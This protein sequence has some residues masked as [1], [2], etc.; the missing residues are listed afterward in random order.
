MEISE[1][2]G[3]TLR[4]RKQVVIRRNPIV[5]ELSLPS[6]DVYQTLSTL[7]WI[8]LALLPLVLGIAVAGGSLKEVV[9]PRIVAFSV[10][11]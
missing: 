4:L 7:E 8:M 11:S 5:V 2:S 9:N 6:E 3:R 10:E 1:A